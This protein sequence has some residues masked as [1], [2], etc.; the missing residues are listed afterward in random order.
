[1]GKPE[2]FPLV[3][4]AEVQGA[5]VADGVGTLFAPAHATAFEPPADNRFAGRLDRTRANLPTV[6][7]IRRVVHALKVVAQ[8]LRFLAMR[9]ANR[10][11]AIVERQLFER[12]EQRRSA[13]LLHLMTPRLSL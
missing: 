6:R 3:G 13:F 10:R 9:F 1:M 2:S 12:G 11:R 4:F 5:Q 7:L 8:V